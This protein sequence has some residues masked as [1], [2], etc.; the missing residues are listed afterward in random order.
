MNGVRGLV[1][2]GLLIARLYLHPESLEP[3]R[4]FHIFG[5]RQYRSK[6]HISPTDP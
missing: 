4:T 3:L 2:V 5:P 6:T 1:G